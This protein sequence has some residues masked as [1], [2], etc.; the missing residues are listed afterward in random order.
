[1]ELYCFR[2]QTD[3][4]VLL[5]SS[6]MVYYSHGGEDYELL[7]DEQFMYPNILLCISVLVSLAINFKRSE[8]FVEIKL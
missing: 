8:V 5:P 6:L 4:D 2:K 3:I 1:M 7:I